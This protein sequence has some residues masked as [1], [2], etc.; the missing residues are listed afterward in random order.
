MVAIK[1]N[2]RQSKRVKTLGNRYWRLNHLYYILD[3]DSNKILYR[4]NAV[5]YALYF[6]MWWL[7]IIP[8]SRQH[9]IT[10]F[11]AIFM[12][13][14]C[15]FN[16]NQRA[17]I[18]A[19]KL[20]D[21]KR[22]FRDKIKYAY[23]NLPA[24]LRG[25]IK[26]LKDDSQELMFSNNSSI[27]VGTSMRSGTLQMLH[28]SEYGWI[29]THM[30]LKAAEIKSGA[31][32]TVHEGGIIFIEA[33]A[34]GPIGDFPEMCDEAGAKIGQDLGPMDY[35]LHFFAWHEKDSNTTDPQYV[36][37]SSDMH[38]YFDKIGKI[39]AKVITPGQRAWYTAK[40][41]I[42][43]HL[44]YKEHPSTLEEAFIAAI[45]GSYYAQEI[46]QAREEGRICNVPHNPKYPVHTV[47]D[48][49]VK[50]NMPWIFFQHIGLETHI[51]DYFN[52]SK[53]DDVRASMS[54]YKAMLDGNKEQYGYNYGKYFAPFDVSKDEIGTG[55]SIYD[56]AKEHGIVFT[57]L[58]REKSVLDGVE[59]VTNLFSSLWINA[60]KC[61]SLVN[62]V[63]AYRREWIES[64]GMYAEKPVHDASSHPADT[65]R[66]LSVVIE[67]KLYIM[68]D[69]GSV[70]NADID[71]WTA[72]YRRTG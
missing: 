19:H 36:E 16:S 56:T 64:A 11:I 23:D 42:L 6:A 21:A 8:K 43:K 27:Y 40:K 24:D 55:Q 37:V 13:D 25:C 26:L 68:D 1:E 22:I 20:A 60:D 48:L 31:L 49:G 53:K 66:Y 33:T 28:I 65:L 15:L 12:L 63:A 72:K 14:A 44:I 39:F 5:Q 10:T 41:K 70:S 29:C 59:R 17:G 71:K 58:P 67:Q 57:K 7:N 2:S 3:E 18:I 4:F 61:K 32:E 54:F 34:E 30:P 47:C 35:K 38:A 52:L 46:S 62:A 50:A 9:G 51:I 69:T 45:E